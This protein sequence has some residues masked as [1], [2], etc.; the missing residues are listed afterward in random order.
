M[1]SCSM[2]Y[3]GQQSQSTFLRADKG[4]TEA[5]GCRNASVAP[6]VRRDLADCRAREGMKSCGDGADLA[7]KTLARRFKRISHSTWIASSRKACAPRRPG[8]QRFAHSAI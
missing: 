2:G 8:P 5:A 1:D 6:T 3:V 4:R 7:T